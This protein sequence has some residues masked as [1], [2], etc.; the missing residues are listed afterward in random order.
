MEKMMYKSKI[1]GIARKPAITNNPSEIAAKEIFISFPRHVNLSNFIPIKFMGATNKA[2]VATIQNS[3]KKL[4][5]KR[6]R[7]AISELSTK[8]RVPGWN[9]IPKE[10]H[11]KAFAGVGKPMKF[12]DCRVSILN[13]ARRNAENAGIIT[14]IEERERRT[15]KAGTCL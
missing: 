14:A 7:R 12:F 1:I 2:D 11:N 4:L 8:Q 15:L 5:S 3:T 9:T 10:A 13:L 6:W